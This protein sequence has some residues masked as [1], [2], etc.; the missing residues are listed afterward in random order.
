MDTNYLRGSEWRKWDLHVHSPESD[1]YRG[2]WD[3]FKT[4]LENADCAVIGINDYFS[5]AGYKKLKEEIKNNTLDIRDKVILPVVEMRMTDSLQ[6]KNI[7]TRSAT[8]FN[9]HII[10]S[11]ELNVDDIESFIK[12]L[13]SGDSIIGSDYSDKTKLKDKKVSFDNTLKKLQSD[14]KFKDSFLMWLPYDEYGGIDSID[15]VS[16][17]WIKGDFI[18][19]SHILGSSNKSQ[20]DFFLWK[21]KLKEDGTRKFSQE[22]FEEWFDYKKPCI[23]G[24]DSHRQD[25]PIG[26][27]RNENSQPIEKF[28]WIKADP[29]FEGLKQIVYEPEDRVR[30]QKENPS[31]EFNKPFFEK[32]A[33]KADITIFK[34]ESVS[35]QDNKGVFLNKNLVTF[36]G[37]RGAGKSLFLK[38]LG[39][40][41]GKLG[42]N[43][44]LQDSEDFVVNYQKE[45]KEQGEQEQFIGVANNL[46]FVF[47]EQGKIKSITEGSGLEVEIK[48]LLGLENLPFDK[49]LND[50]IVKN[51]NDIAKIKL[52]FEEKDENANL[53]NTKEY[54]EKIKNDNEKLLNTITTKSN[55]KKLESYTN[56]IKEIEKLKNQVQV[57]E[58]FKSKL[59]RYKESLN[60][61]IA[62]INGF[63]EG[64][65]LKLFKI[66]FKSVLEKIKR[67]TN[68]LEQQSSRKQTENDGIKEEF[69]RE[70]FKGDLTTL[71]ENAKVYQEKIE[72]AKR[73]IKSIE[74]QERSLNSLKTTRRDFGQKI[75]IEYER[76]KTEW[77]T[78]W[79]NL[80]RD[81]QGKQK[82][83]I[84]GIIL[85]KDIGFKVSIVFD[86]DKFYQLIYDKVDKR[87]YKDAEK[88]KPEFNNISNFESWISFFVDEKFNR[89]IDEDY[90][91]NSFIK[92][93]FFDLNTRKQYIKVLPELTYKNKTIDKLS[94]GQKGTVYLRLQLA[95]NA[96]STPIIFDQPEDDLDNK[97]IVTELVPMMKK[98]KR[99]RQ[100]IIATHN[101][102]LV[103]GADA[104]Q[105]IVAN[106]EDE[107]LSYTSG[108]I[109]NKEIKE[110]VC[111][112]LEGG[113]D[114][115]D[116]RKKKYNF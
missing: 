54:S 111:E 7:S 18:K 88:L 67:Q 31:F 59:L 43:S 40:R 30:I 78:E 101:A 42:D 37:G 35:F 115:F 82:E 85:R 58:S 45:N 33:V 25:Y 32:I 52:W 76:Q 74:Q 97:F 80:L 23:K 24:S 10:F 89:I 87:S 11:N 68:H 90:H 95:T 20:I 79:N 16:D 100:I 65:E 57:I 106:N 26:K 28:T 113:K 99:Y 4:Q 41:F 46:N 36:I 27:L 105:I 48:K 94:A 60:Q 3:G 81:K 109:E 71:L 86:A 104:E 55:K 1:G 34:N 53:I 77:E 56:N 83:L 49:H 92:D 102:N 8:H 96:F 64:E 51:I 103:V 12:S 107:I 44:A 38:Y 112:I 39:S 13:E 19:K 47:I 5:V 114:A 70:G 108:S 29:T 17:S 98:L 93:I 61:D 72:Q 22:Q 73:T 15:P 84:E 69:E 116:K 62:T 66:N 75:K 9:F 21:S 91:F 110:R 63:F 14:K 50:K 6:S 2:T